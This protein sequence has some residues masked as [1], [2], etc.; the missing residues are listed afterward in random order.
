MRDNVV[1]HYVMHGKAISGVTYRGC[2]DVAKAHG[3]IALQCG[4]PGI[5]CGGKHG[6]QQSNWHGAVE[7]LNKMVDRCRFRPPA[8]TADS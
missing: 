2:S 1:A 7:I 5:G 4:D 3:A 8:K 6:P